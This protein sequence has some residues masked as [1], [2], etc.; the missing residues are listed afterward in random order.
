MSSVP[1]E[2]D[3]L[4]NAKRIVN[5]LEMGMRLRD[6]NAPAYVITD[7]Q[8]FTAAHSL[9]FSPGLTKDTL[10]LLQVVYN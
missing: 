2:Y 9:T 10:I 7:W 6:L 8:N 3:Q 5:L 1:N 4:N